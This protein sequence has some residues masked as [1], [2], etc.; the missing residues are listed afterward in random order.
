M[1]L[2][3]WGVLEAS[4]QRGERLLEEE[5]WLSSIG[6]ESSPSSPTATGAYLEELDFDLKKNMERQV[7][8]RDERR[9]RSYCEQRYHSNRW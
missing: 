7:R 3:S 8:E 2:G 6:V 5:S 9:E 1:S 4:N